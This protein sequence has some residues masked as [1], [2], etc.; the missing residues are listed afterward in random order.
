MPVDSRPFFGEVEAALVKNGSDFRLVADAEKGLPGHT[1][2]P[3]HVEMLVQIC[4]MYRV[5]PDPRSLKLHEIRFFYEAIRKTL[6][7]STATKR[8]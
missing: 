4:L 8:R 6:H 3:V 1:L 5:L 7:K 2:I